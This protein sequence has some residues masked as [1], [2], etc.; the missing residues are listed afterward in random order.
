MF[1]DLVITNV[2]APSSIFIGD[3]FSISWTIEN[4][5]ILA[6]NSNIYSKVVFSYD[7]VYDSSDLF[8]TYEA[9]DNF[10]ENPLSPGESHTFTAIARDHT[11]RQLS[12]GE[13]FLVVVADA[14]NFEQ[15]IDENNNIYAVPTLVQ[16]PDVDLIITNVSIPPSS[17]RQG[18]TFPISWT[19]KN[20]GSMATNA[21]LLSS[22]IYFS[23]DTIYDGLDI[24]L[25]DGYLRSPLAAGESHTFTDIADDYGTSQLPTGEGFILSLVDIANLQAETDESNNGYVV[26]TP[27]TVT[28]SNDVDLVITQASAPTI[29]TSQNNYVSWTVQ[30][31]GSQS[32]DIQVSCFYYKFSG[33]CSG[34]LNDSVYFSS[35]EN[36]DDSDILL[37][38]ASYYKPTAIP[39]YSSGHSYSFSAGTSYTQGVKLDLSNVSQLLDGYL[40]FR[41]N[42][43]NIH[44]IPSVYRYRAGAYPESN[45]N[46]NTFAVPITILPSGFNPAQYG[47]SNP[48]LIQTFGYDLAAFNQHYIEF[49]YAEKRNIDSFDERSY[50]ASYDDLIQYYGYDLE[51]ATEHY[52]RYGF[53]EERTTNHFK[54]DQYLASH[55]DLIQYYGYSLSQASLH[56]I[57]HGFYEGRSPDL[58]EEGIYLASHDDLIQHYGDDFEGATKHYIRHG[59]D[60]GR[61]TDGFAPTQ[62]LASHDD[63][64]QYYGDDLEGATKHYIQNGFDEGRLRDN[65][66]EDIYLASHNDLIEAFAYDLEAATLHYIDRGMSEGRAKY[67]FDPTAYLNNYTDLQAAFGDDLT[68]ATQHYILYGYAEGRTY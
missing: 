9:L 7:N 61:T 40:L 6:T 23:T 39:V 48:D 65:F 17:L 2:I 36:Y 41:T 16:L 53:Y 24:S 13:G 44:H 42:D 21:Y 30:N 49:G 19:I 59:F 5:G 67:Q 8:L 50:L 37:A 18:D 55:A 22:G 66:W 62:Y 64:I 45:R 3:T 31:Q 60:E 63:L 58:F 28:P 33:N 52:I 27:L 10:Q 15:E 29:V 20:Q 68:A 14:N 25:A 51:G 34:V 38:S 56:F 12:V 32:L 4:Q 26:A 47:A 46:N 1:P 43:I 54:A 11:T 35:D 57:I